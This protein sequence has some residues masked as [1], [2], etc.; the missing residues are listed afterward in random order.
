M[1]EAGYSGHFTLDIDGSTL[2]IGDTSGVIDRL[3]K[4]RTYLERYFA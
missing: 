3:Q 2:G 4:S 1:K